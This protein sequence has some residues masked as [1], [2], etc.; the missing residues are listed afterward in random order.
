MSEKMENIHLLKTKPAMVRGKGVGPP[1]RCNPC[2]GRT[3]RHQWTR[4]AW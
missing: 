2:S 3:S 1:C 4:K